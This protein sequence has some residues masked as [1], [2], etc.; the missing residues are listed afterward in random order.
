LVAG[1]AVYAPDREIA[2]AM[3]ALRTAAT[4]ITA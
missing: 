2:D 4:T 1:S 3:D